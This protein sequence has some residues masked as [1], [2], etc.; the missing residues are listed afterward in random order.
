MA[1][2]EIIA[3]LKKYLTL[4]KAEGISVEKAI[5]YGSYSSNTATESSDIDLMIVTNDKDANDDLIIGKIWSLTRKINT[6]IEPFLISSE[7]FNQ[8]T[9]SP[10]VDLIK[11][12]GVEIVQQ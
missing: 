7:R 9:D 4:L 11:S 1:N 3:L 6:R 5:L 12:K 2:Q 8:N 10:L